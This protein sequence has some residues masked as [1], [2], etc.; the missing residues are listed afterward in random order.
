MHFLTN[1]PIPVSDKPPSSSSSTTSPP[2][3]PPPP[4]FVVAIAV[5][6]PADRYE[7]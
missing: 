1:S 3:P 5:A 7:L 4:L 6:E 2:P